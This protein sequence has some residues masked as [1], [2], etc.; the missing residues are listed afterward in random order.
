MILSPHI[1]EIPRPLVPEELNSV[2]KCRISGEIVIHHDFVKNNKED[3][4]EYSA[5]GKMHT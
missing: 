3:K 2:G 1:K 4:G 5:N